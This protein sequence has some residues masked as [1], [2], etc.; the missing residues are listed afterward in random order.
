METQ[1]I[2]FAGSFVGTALMALTSLSGILSNTINASGW[3]AFSVEA[4]L[5][6]A[7]GYFLFFKRESITPTLH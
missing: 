4:L 7:F 5:A 1:R 2:V 6:L 3:I